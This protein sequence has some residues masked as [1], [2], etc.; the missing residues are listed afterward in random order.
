MT[1]THIYIYIHIFIISLHIFNYIQ[2]HVTHIYIAN[3]IRYSV[4]LENLGS[5]K[6]PFSILLIVE[7]CE[8]QYDGSKFGDKP[9]SVEH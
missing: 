6:W 4:V 8:K 5:L 2:L 3:S 1:H 9:M 7:H